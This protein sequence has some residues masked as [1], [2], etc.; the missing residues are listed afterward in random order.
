MNNTRLVPVLS[1][2][3]ALSLASV[4]HADVKKEEKSLV[5]F[6]GLLGRMANLFGGK[7]A[8]EGVI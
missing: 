4:L 1:L 5:T 8:K 7:A 2:V 3:L 6:S